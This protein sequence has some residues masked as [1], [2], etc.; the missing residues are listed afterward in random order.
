MQQNQ[1]FALAPIAAAVAAALHPAPSMAA[2]ELALEEVVVTARK[3]AESVQDIPSSIQ[4]FSEE[5]L[6]SPRINPRK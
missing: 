2:D 3:R 5:M 6:P 1:K 4:A